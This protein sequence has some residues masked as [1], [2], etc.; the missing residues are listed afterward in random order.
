MN[1]EPGFMARLTFAFMSL[2]MVFLSITFV[3]WA[4]NL[5]M[6]VVR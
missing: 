6:G 4:W 2:G 3:V 5:L 1:K